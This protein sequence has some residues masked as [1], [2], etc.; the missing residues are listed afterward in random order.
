MGYLLLLE[1]FGKTPP[2]TKFYST[3]ANGAVDNPH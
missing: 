2:F 1:R 3:L